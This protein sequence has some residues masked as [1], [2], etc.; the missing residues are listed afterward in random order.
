LLD[1]LAWLP[2]MMPGM[3]LGI[4]LL[5]GFA[6][7]P[8]PVQIYGTI[9]ALFVA[10]V[11]LGTPLATQIMSAS[12]AQLSFDIEECSRVHGAGALT[13]MRR[14]VIALVYPAFMSR[15][16]IRAFI[17]DTRKRGSLCFA[18]SSTRGNFC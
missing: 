11:S 14:I 18:V 13:T 10:Y 5:W 7:L 2:W 4:G 8:G 3:V 12:F 16:E 17:A 15:G 9:W 1:A 6:L